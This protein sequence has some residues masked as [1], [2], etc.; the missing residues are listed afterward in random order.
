MV[1]V[2][3]LMFLLPGRVL[4]FG[5]EP[6][7]SMRLWCPHRECVL[8]LAFRLRKGK[9]DMGLTFTQRM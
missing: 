8:H 4:R 2:G 1:T 9:F 7:M 6:F 5:T 3:S